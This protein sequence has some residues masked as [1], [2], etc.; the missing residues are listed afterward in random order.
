MTIMITQMSH[1]AAESEAEVSQENAQPIVTLAEEI[2]HQSVKIEELSQLIRSGT[3]ATKVGDGQPSGIRMVPMK[4]AMEPSEDE[5]FSLVSLAGGRSHQ[6]TRDQAFS[7]QQV[8]PKKNA[9]ANRRNTGT[10]SQGA[11]P[12]QE[13]ENR[14]Q[15]AVTQATLDTWGAQLIT[16]GSKHNGKNFARVFEVDPGYTKWVTDRYETVHP[17]MRNYA[18][19]AQTRK[20]LEKQASS[21]GWLLIKWL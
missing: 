2:H 15:V 16:W 17:E 5:N 7:M 3:S 14:R 4:E 8:S 20:A 6:E 9:R 19:Y 18:D 11:E 10:M 21:Q 12:H 1:L 13:E